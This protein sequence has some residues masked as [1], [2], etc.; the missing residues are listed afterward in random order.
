VDAAISSLKPY[1]HK[2]DL[3]IDGGNSYFADTE[4]RLKDLEQDGLNF[5]G[6]GVSGGESGARWGP[7]LMP[8]GSEASWPC[9]QAMFEAI[10]AKTEDGEP[11]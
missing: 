10:A 2:G 6:M 8:G 9:V 5:I 4:R 1:L 3:I 7:S 11:A